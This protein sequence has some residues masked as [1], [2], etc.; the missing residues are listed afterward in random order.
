MI[1]KILLLVGASQAFS[2]EEDLLYDSFPNDF[3]WGA[4][5]AAYQVVIPDGSLK[6][7]NVCSDRGWMGSGW[8][9]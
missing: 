5:T 2:P 1:I 8:E 3:T 9:G 4:A 6:K 7:S